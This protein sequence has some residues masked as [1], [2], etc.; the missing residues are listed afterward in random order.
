MYSRSVYF[1]R[2]VDLIIETAG[3]IGKH[4]RII[5]TDMSDILRD[6]AMAGHG[7]AWLPESTARRCPPGALVPL[8]DDLWSLP[9]SIVALKDR[10]LEKPAVARLWSVL[11]GGRPPS[12][13]VSSRP[14][15]G[16]VRAR[17][18]SPHS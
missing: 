16:F 18:G 15:T 9:L 11:S 10:K 1:A 12:P 8:G 4:T 6:M 7:I 17:S 13:A 2:L 3:G 14:Q 5:E